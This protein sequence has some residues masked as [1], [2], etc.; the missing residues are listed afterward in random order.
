MLALCGG[1]FQYIFEV[2][3]I[4]IMVFQIIHRQDKNARSYPFACTDQCDFVLLADFHSKCLSLFKIQAVTSIFN[5]LP[6]SFSFYLFFSYLFFDHNH[7]YLVQEKENCAGDCKTWCPKDNISESQGES[8]SGDIVYLQGLYLILF[9]CQVN[10]SLVILV[11]D[12]N[13]RSHPQ[14]DVYCLRISLDRCDQEWGVV[15]FV[16][17]VHL[18]SP[19]TRQWL[20]SNMIQEQKNKKC[21]TP[22]TPC[23]T[24]HFYAKGVEGNSTVAS[25]IP[26]PSWFLVDL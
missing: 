26:W 24:F 25:G 6:F 8:Q 15:I 4:W 2:I 21:Y 19:E 16:F 5:I 3:G 10:R 1:R 22:D 7:N 13:V 17:T 12:G 23:C 20:F 18:G 9:S 11:T 14:Q